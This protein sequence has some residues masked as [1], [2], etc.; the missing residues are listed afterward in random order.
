MLAGCP[1]AETFSMGHIKAWFLV[2]HEHGPLVQKELVKDIKLSENVYPLLLDETTK[3][4]VK[5]MSSNSKNQVVTRYI[6]SKLFG[7]AKA[8][9][10][11]NKVIGVMWK[12]RLDLNQLFNISTSGPKINE[13]LRLKVNK[14]MRS[15]EYNGLIPL[16][17]CVLHT[18]RSGFHY[19]TIAYGN[20]VE[21][22]G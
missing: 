6:Y 2:R 8:D 21:N 16:V 15:L 10:P 17:H 14:Q 13:S 5:Q 12:N 19:G 18:F 11:C 7:H 4:V 9:D 22:L 1:V 20:E 3:Q